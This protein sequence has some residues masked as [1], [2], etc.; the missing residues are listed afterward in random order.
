MNRITNADLDVV[1]GRYSRAL[2]FMNIRKE[3]CE[4]V[5]GQLYGQCYTIAWRDQESGGMFDAP[6]SIMVNTKRE[7]FNHLLTAART[8]EDAYWELSTSE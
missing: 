8:L 4:L 5:Y 1:F 7:L 6:G 2:E 3:G